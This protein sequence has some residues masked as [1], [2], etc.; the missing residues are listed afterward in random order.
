MTKFNLDML[1]ESVLDRVIRRKLNPSQQAVHDYVNQNVRHAT[2]T[3]T[4]GKSNHTTWR[5]TVDKPH[6]PSVIDVAA[7]HFQDQGFDLKTT[8]TK[9]SY[10]DPIREHILTRPDGEGTHEIVRV[11]H[12][13]AMDTL[14]HDYVEFFHS[15]GI[16][17]KY[18]PN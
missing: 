1:V 17:D 13:A 12:I 9:K 4:R 5:V 8:A 7:K 11:A 18:N 14:P 6:A 16:D 15:H 3:K 2:P 10:A